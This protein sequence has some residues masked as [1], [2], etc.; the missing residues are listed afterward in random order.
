MVRRWNREHRIA[1]QLFVI[2][3][4]LVFAGHGPHVSTARQ[5]AMMLAERA[6][7]AAIGMGVGALRHGPIEIAQ[8]DP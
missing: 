7:V 4:R 6:R 5:A 3:E 8:P 1:A 2:D